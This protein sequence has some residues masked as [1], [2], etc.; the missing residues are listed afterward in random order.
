MKLT[1]PTL[2]THL[3]S[4]P[5]PKLKYKGKVLT[6]EERRSVYEQRMEGMKIEYLAAVYGVANSTIIKVIKEYHVKS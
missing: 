6:P 1:V 3:K 5:I 4:Q 2:K